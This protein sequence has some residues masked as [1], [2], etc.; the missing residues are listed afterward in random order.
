MF[1][2]G[3]RCLAVAAG[4]VWNSVPVH[5]GPEAPDDGAT[6]TPA[7]RMF[8]TSAE[9]SELARMHGLID[10]NRIESM[11]ELVDN[12]LGTIAKLSSYMKPA[13]RPQIHK[14]SRA[15][16]EHTVCRGPCPVKAWHVPGEGIFLDEALTPESNLVD[17]SVLLH[18]LVHFIQE[19][20]GASTLTDNC[21]G[22]A[23][24]RAGSLRGAEPVPLAGGQRPQL[25]RDGGQPV[26]DHCEPQQLRDRRAREHGA[27]SAKA[28]RKGAEVC[29]GRP[30]SLSDPNATF[31]AGK[32]VIRRWSPI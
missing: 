15:Q 13:A 11:P 27:V 7:R 18:E 32:A 12:L 29:A 17:R 30:R 22:V 8:A 24:A 19:V 20:D 28:R 21:P 2:S 1:S 3:L 5:A 31:G 23:P 25:S 4:L 9:H 16:I 6:P 26:L 14:V 10:R